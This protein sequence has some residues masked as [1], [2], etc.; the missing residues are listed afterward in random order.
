[1]VM[2]GFLKENG[3]MKRG[4]VG[5]LNCIPMLASTLDNLSKTKL[6]AKGFTLG[7]MGRSMMESGLKE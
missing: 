4:T 6:K 3:R 5:V 7:G 1:M 2:A